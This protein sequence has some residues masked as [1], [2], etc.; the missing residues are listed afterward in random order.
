MSEAT[1]LRRPA[2]WAAAALV[3]LAALP[4]GCGRDDD[5]RAQSAF[6]R[7]VDLAP[8]RVIAVQDTG[9]IKSL[10]TFARR[11][12]QDISGP[13]RV[14]GQPPALTCLDMLFRPEQYLDE[15]LIYVKKKPIRQALATA[16]S[17]ATGVDAERLARIR[18][19]GLISRRLL[20][21]PGAVLLLNSLE[22]DV[23][24]TA[25]PVNAIRNAQSLAA[26]RA[27]AFVLRIV[28]PPGGG[29]EDEWLP[30][31]LLAADHDIP[32][33]AAHADVG[34]AAVSGLDAELSDEL[35]DAWQSLTAAW[36]RQDAA[37]SSS[38][39]AR[40]A[41]LLPRVNAAV[42]PD[43]RR[44]LWESWYFRTKNL[45]WVWVLYLLAIVPL[46]MSVIY[47]WTWARAA[48]LGLFVVAFGLHT[49]A[50]L[51]RWY[52]AQR[53]PNSNMFEA[54]TTA[55]WFG[56]AV[57]LVLEGL[58]RRTAVRNLF[59][60]GSAAASMAA[61]MAAYYLP[62]Q[63]NA[64]IGNRMPILHDIWLY[65]HTNV[66]IA[67]YCLIAMAGASALLYLAYRLLGGSAAVATAG[68]AGALILAAGPADSFLKQEPSRTT[69]GQVLDAATLVLMELAFVLLWAG[70]VMGAIW[71][72]HSWG[73]PWGWDPKEVF[74]LNTFIVF[75]LL[76]HIRLK[77]RDKG[78]W[79]A[80]LAVA[81]CAV[82]LFNWIV[83]N[84]VIT[85]LHSYA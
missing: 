43:A 29:P 23:R 14:A 17:A 38:A 54:V 3:A 69:A 31:E 83:V 55:A 62:V 58:V 72:D 68:G 47:R 18:E 27:L 82:M 11:V 52:L 64:H 21:E 39:L 48:G 76:V 44:L 46:L 1:R 12:M 70:I 84:F 15:D 59:A 19:T 32:D 41:E 6:A 53:W 45:T 5:E 25:G 71:A 78:L 77:V 74:A 42:Y 30:A 34:R 50:L 8:L 56:G 33:D 49:A 57:A 2:A 36:Q 35:A 26:A 81:G 80:V 9:R 85:G 7:Q 75:L 66:I 28:P 10:E 65:I 73:R 24:R 67:S 4:A 63:L 22:R 79:T 61:M 13:R 51:L 16:V 20:G 37:A 60:L 40:L